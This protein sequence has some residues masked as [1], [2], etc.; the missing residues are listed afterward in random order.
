METCEHCVR[1]K[2]NERS[3]EQRKALKT[4]INRINGQLNGINSMIDDNRYCG[5]ILIQLS[6][7]IQGLKQVAY[8][9]LK[10][11]M[12]TCVASDLKE[13]KYD[14][15]EEMVSLMEKLK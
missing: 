1:H 9:I 12:E 2:E 5:D 6:A 7:S 3:I 8:M 11:H 10:D 14:S 15:L 13:D 4:R